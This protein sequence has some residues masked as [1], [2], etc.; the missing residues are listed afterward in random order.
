M[1]HRAVLGSLERFI[2][3][4]VE[5]TG[6]D[7]PLWLAPLQVRVLPI[8]ERHLA[9][10]RTV[11]R[12]LEGAGIRAEVDDRNEK[13]GFKIREAELRKIPVMLVVGDQEQANGTVTPRRRQESKE[14][15]GAIS[16]DALVAQL[17][18]EI[19]DRRKP[20]RSQEE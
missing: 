15:S 12:E 17:T 19:D 10:A 16:V 7:F 9:Y 3:L 11:G 6:G 1:L 18:R 13:L 8:A 14:A 2:A 5:Q 4:Y 20:R